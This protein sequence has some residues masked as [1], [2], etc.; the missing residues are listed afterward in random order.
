[1]I[2][3]PVKEIKL[4]WHLKAMLEI[5]KELYERI[6]DTNG[7]AFHFNE[8]CKLAETGDLWYDSKQT[9]LDLTSVEKNPADW[10]QAAINALRLE[11]DESIVNDVQQKWDLAKEFLLTTQKP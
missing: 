2:V 4:W 6:L 3:H 5:D 11:L 10:M 8:I 7:F 9:P 1:M